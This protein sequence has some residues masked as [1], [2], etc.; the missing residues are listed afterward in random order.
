[1][2]EQSIP[3]TVE[4]E[5]ILPIIKR[6]LYTNREIFL[7]EL[8]SN[9]IDALAKLQT[10]RLSSKIDDDDE[11]LRVEILV[12]PFEKTVSILDNG[13]GMSK[14][15]VLRYINQLTFSCAKKIIIRKRGV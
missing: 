4:A 3:L 8:I 15:E 11:P 7:R 12:D 1:M 9:A 5:D 13:I 6:F 2:S 10:I 14:D